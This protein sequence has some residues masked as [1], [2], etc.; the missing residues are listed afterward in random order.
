MKSPELLKMIHQVR[1]K[2]MACYV[3]EPVP[4]NFL[5]EIVPP[6][7]T[8]RFVM[9]RFTQMQ[10]KGVPVY[11]S[12]LQVNSVHWRLKVYPYGNGAV[13]GEYLSVFLELTIGYPETSKY[14]YRVQMIHQSASKNIQREFVSDFE[15]GECWGYNRFFRLDLLASEGYLNSQNDTLE[16]RF[17]VRPSTFYQ[18]CRDQQWFISQLLRKQT[19]QDRK[20]KDLKERL[21]HEQA[22]HKATIA[23]AT[24]AGCNVK[25]A[26]RKAVR[27]TE[28]IITSGNKDSLASI[29][30]VDNGNVTDKLMDTTRNSPSS[31]SSST[32]STSSSSS[33]A[34]AAAASIK[35][36]AESSSVSSATAQEPS[37]AMAAAAT[38][39]T[40]YTFQIAEEAT[41][42]N[43]HNN[44]KL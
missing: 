28:G 15:V 36:S 31:S 10:Q 11:S 9:E 19:D 33:S 40:D 42:E 18:R 23:A 2:P 12:P 30:A 7:D 26:A 4:A 41:N 44:G 5:S 14:E 27:L 1:L 20:V 29:K 17:H 16:L 43:N 13:R 21:R 3:T 22:N 35:A 38:S 37:G 34:A 39:T 24:A 32:S 6:Y 25:S 8:G